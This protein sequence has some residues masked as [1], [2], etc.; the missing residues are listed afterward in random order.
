MLVRT[1]SEVDTRK[2]HFRKW[3]ERPVAIVILC[4]L[5]PRRFRDKMNGC[6]A[7]WSIYRSFYCIRGCRKI[8]SLYWWW[9]SSLLAE[10]DR[11]TLWKWRHFITK[12]TRWF[13]T[14]RMDCQDWRK[15]PRKMCNSLKTSWW[16]KSIRSW[17]IVND[18]TYWWIKKLQPD[19][20]MPNF[21]WTKSST[22]ANICRLPCGIYSING[23]LL[24]W[25]LLKVCSH[26]RGQTRAGGKL[27]STQII[28]CIHTCAVAE[29]RRSKSKNR[30][31]RNGSNTRH[32]E[33]YR[34]SDIGW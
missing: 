1:V 17:V 4:Q 15:P 6:F 27:A 23:R 10:N 16:E 12:R 2:S 31:A 14:S 29:Q 34:S 11:S 26:M 32:R 21:V 13:M 22:I 20:P 5:W 18:W 33:T 30:S 7:I 28:T 8:F 9:I 3:A 19:V 24:G 25:G